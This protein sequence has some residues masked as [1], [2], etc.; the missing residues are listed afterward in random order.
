MNTFFVATGRAAANGVDGT[1]DITRKACTET[2]G[3][4]KAFVP[5]GNRSA[6]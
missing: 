3:A 2:S 6:R 4:S 1:Y 5:A